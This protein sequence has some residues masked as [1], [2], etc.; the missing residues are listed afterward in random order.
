MVSGKPHLI[1]SL[2]DKHSVKD[3]AKR[4]PQV[5]LDFKRNPWAAENVINQDGSFEQASHAQF[6]TTDQKQL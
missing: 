3:D 6:I 2:V 1:V 5:E 4:P